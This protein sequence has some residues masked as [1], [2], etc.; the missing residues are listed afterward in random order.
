MY[1]SWIH[2]G[3]VSD[4]YKKYIA[5]KEVPDDTYTEDRVALFRVQGSGPDN[6]QAIQVEPVCPA[7][8]SLLFLLYILLNLFTMARQCSDF[9]LLVIKLIVLILRMQFFL[10]LML[11]NWF[12]MPVSLAFSALCGLPELESPVCKFAHI[13]IFRQ[14]FEVDHPFILLWSPSVSN[15]SF[16]PVLWCIFSYY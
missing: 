6:M 3:G 16:S 10:F 14:Q 5:E 13:F 15:I 4:G 8:I 12:L 1:L 7:F 11:E 9:A 2:Q